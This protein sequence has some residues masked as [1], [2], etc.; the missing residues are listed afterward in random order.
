SRIA[1]APRSPPRAL[2]V[3]P[4][5]SA[6]LVGQPAGLRLC[7][8]KTRGRRDFRI[9]IVGEPA[10]IVCHRSQLG[11]AGHDTLANDANNPWKDEVLARLHKDLFRITMRCVWLDRKCPRRT[12]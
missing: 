6:G 5:A 11:A 7:V 8:R 4:S 9:L 1:L 12:S 3:P 10:A 2:D